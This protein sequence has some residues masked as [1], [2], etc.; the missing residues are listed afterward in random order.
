MFFISD[1]GYELVLVC[2]KEGIFV[3]FILGFIVGMMVLIVLG[4]VF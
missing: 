3:I 1:F 4:L 2:I